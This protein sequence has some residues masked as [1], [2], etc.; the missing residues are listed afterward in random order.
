MTPSDLGPVSATL[1]ADLRNRSEGTG[2]CSGSTSTT[3]TPAS[4]IG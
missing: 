4:S 3:T 1:E 2:S